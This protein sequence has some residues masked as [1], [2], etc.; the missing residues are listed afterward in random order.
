MEGRVQNP[1]FGAGRLNRLGRAALARLGGFDSTRP[2]GSAVVGIE[3][4]IE[5]CPA[6]ACIMRELP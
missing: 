5:N 1:K 6:W 2:H 4:D 3:P